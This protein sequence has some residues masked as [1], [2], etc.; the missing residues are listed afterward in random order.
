MTVVLTIVFGLLAGI[1]GGMGP[2]GGTMS[3]T[4]FQFLDHG[5]T[6]IQ[7][8]NLLSFI[9]MAAVALNFHFKNRLVQT[10]GVLW[11]VIPAV[12]FCVLGTVF[13]HGAVPKVLK[14]CFGAFLTAVGLWEICRGISQA[15]KDKK[16]KRKGQLAGGE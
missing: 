9:P 3:I 1:A 16:E 2:G 13:A 12:L 8:M 15:R 10:K 4:L 5:Q 6:A 11:V 7:V 14:I